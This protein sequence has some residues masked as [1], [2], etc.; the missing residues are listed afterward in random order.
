MIRSLA[1]LL[2]LAVPLQAGLPAGPRATPSTVGGEYKSTLLYTPPDP[3]ATGGL[4]FVSSQPLEFAFAVPENNQEHVYKGAIDAAKTGVS[5]SNLPVAM[6]DLVLAATGQFYEGVSLNRDEN[7]LAPGDLAAIEEIFSRSVPFF[8]VKRTV[9]VKGT[10]GD[11]GQ[12]AAIVQWMRIGGNLMNQNADLMVG[13][14]IRSLRMAFLA[15]VGVGWQVTATREIIRTDVF[16]KDMNK[17]MLPVSYVD[18]LNG[19]RVVDSVKDVGA[20]DL[21]AGVPVDS[22]SPADSSSP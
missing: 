20:I 15:D 12:A 11:Q 7:S 2:L 16:P 22:S 19:V 18:A 1:A 14:Q 17:G 5:F 6:Y 9:V 21:S 4:R 13:H 3:S 10:P 8:N